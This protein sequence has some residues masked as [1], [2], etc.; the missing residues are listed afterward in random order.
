MRSLCNG[1][2]AACPVHVVTTTDEYGKVKRCVVRNISFRGA[3][4]F[5]VND[6]VDSDDFPTEWGTA[7]QVA[8]LVSSSLSLSLLSFFAGSFLAALHLIYPHI[9]CPYVRA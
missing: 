9:N 3:A 6:L 1:H 8:D 5:S 7:S 4:G 2:Y